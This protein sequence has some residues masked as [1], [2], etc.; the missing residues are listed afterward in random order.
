[1]K[2]RDLIKALSTLNPELDVFS[3]KAPQASMRFGDDP[4]RPI[5]ATYLHRVAK[6]RVNCEDVKIPVATLDRTG[7]GL[8]LDT[9][10]Q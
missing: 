10:G 4:I 9:E 2:L 6:N 5:T 8:D 1:M 7:C 3:V